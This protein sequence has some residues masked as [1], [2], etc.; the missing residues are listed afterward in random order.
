[1]A[2]PPSWK[3]EVQKTIEETAQA[4]R[5]QRETQTNNAAA[6]IATAIESLRDA[7]NT[8]TSREDSNAKINTAL[9]GVTI[10]LVS[11]TVVF[12]G[13][14]WCAFRDQLTETQRVYPEIKKSAD[15][16]KTAADAALQQAEAANK[17]VSVM[18]RQLRPYLS[19]KNIEF[20]FIQDW[21]GRVTAINRG[22]TPARQVE[23]LISWDT[24]PRC[25]HLNKGFWYHYKDDGSGR[26][27]PRDQKKFF[28]HLRAFSRDD[29]DTATFTLSGDLTEASKA[30]TVCIYGAFLY[31]L[32]TGGDRDT[33]FCWWYRPGDRGRDLCEDQNDL[34]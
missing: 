32:P 1:M 29:E 8:Q 23:F 30:A 22:Q 11:L 2:L 15:A 6:Q 27:D 14:S 19:V 7:Q 4:N 28:D 9:N 24:D 10:F 20:P 33:H 26:S 5:S 34:D 13:L 21:Q 31:A 18:E 17:Q 12:T 3:G 16:A 25:G